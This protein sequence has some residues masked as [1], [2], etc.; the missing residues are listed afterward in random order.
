MTIKE[1]RP[2]HYGLSPDGWS[3]KENR[4]TNTSLIH[5]KSTAHI[6]E[7]QELELSLRQAMKTQAYWMLILANAFGMIVNSGFGLHC[8]PF[9]TDLGIDPTVAGGMMAMMILFSIPSNYLGG[10]LADHARKE[11]LRYILAGAY[12]SQA[13]GIAAFLVKPGA[14]ML[15]VLLILFGFGIGPI[16]PLLIIIRGR[17]YGRKA[18]GSIEGTSLTFEMPFALLS[19]VY[20]GWIYDRTGSYKTAFM[21]FALLS[22]CAAFM[23]VLVR[24]P[25]PVNTSSM[26]KGIM[27]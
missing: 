18:Y 25:A 15:Y 26:D 8:I 9:I 13:L 4:T 22:A 16:R 23:M 11:H 12:V 20:A 17:F 19:P 27:K 5:D 2:E 24:H 1:K 21:L 7:Y 6:F 14:V 3:S 10:L